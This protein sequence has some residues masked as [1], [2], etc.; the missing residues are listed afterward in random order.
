V[1]A[2]ITAPNFG[3]PAVPSG[4]APTRNDPRIMQFALKYVF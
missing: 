4:T 3:V 1:V 2:S